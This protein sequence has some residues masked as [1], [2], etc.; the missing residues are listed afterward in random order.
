MSVLD[1]I[2]DQFPLSSLEISHLIKTAPS[3]YK[4]HEIV[5]RNGRGK[6]TIA[7]PTAEVKLLQRFLME[8]VIPNL[9]IHDAAKAYRKNYS[10][11]NHAL[12]HA[13]K[14]YLLKLDFKNFF[15]SLKATD[16][17]RHL[18]NHTKLSRE[19]IRLLARVFFWR[20][21]GQRKLI[22]SIGAP[23]SPYISNTLLFDFDRKLGE[24]CEANEIV[25]TR[26]ADDLALSTD[27][28]EVLKLAHKYVREICSG[29]KHP[30]LELNEEKTVYTSK[31]H[32]RELTGLTL[33]NDGKASIGRDRKRLIR[34]MT[35]NFHKGTLD[36]EEHSKLRGWISFAL[37][38]DQDF[39]RTLREMIG[40]DSFDKLMQYP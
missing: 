9:P 30:Q 5:K 16:F 40:N 8:A 25:Y 20:P 35:Y 27:R 23:S 6:R 11:V 15:P 10:I 19:D 26:Y 17:I 33:S 22:L 2:S 36:L 3:R 18:G 7:Q 14:H 31:K 12:P 38:V 29:N 13:K 1:V 4:V 32:H 37:S 34:S 21:S 28:P 39:V 24:F